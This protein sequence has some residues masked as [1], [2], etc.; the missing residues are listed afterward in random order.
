MG[1]KEERFPFPGKSSGKGIG[2]FSSGKDSL[3]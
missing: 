3:T 1:H 2:Q